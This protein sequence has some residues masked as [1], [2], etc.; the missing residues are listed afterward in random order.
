MWGYSMRIVVGITGGSGAI[1]GVTLLRILRELGIETHLVVSEMGKYVVRHECDMEIEELKA[2]ADY[3]HE[4]IDLAASIASGSFKSDGMIIVPC[5]MKTLAAIAHGYSDNLLARAA[6]V[7]MKEGRRLVVVPREMPFGVIHLENMLILAKQGVRIMPPNPG[8]YSQPETIEDL[9]NIV[10]G[11][12]LDQ[13]DI[14]HNLLKRWG[15]EEN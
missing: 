8:F 11:R 14:E 12:I 15:E 6:D 9:V 10:I 3:Y 13:F 7:I 4:N 2:M 5:S 1:Y